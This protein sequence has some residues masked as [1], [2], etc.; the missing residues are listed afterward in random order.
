MMAD[1]K[2]ELGEAQRRCFPS[3]QLAPPPMLGLAGWG[4][5]SAHR[6]CQQACSM[7]QAPM[8]GHDQLLGCF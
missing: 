1:R 7:S 5:W 8:C 4:L 3:A 6:S 2:P